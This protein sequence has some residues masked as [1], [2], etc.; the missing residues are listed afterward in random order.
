MKKIVIATNN[1]NKIKEISAILK[2]DDV[3]FLSLKDLNI[4]FDVEETGLTFKKNA[5]KKA[6]EYYKLCKLPVIAE[7]SGLEIKSLNGMPGV[8]SKRIYDGK[9]EY[10]GNEIILE[11]LKG[12]NDRTASYVASYCYYDGVKKLFAEGRTFGRIAL[13]Q[14]GENGFAYDKIFISD[15]FKK[16]MSMISDEEKN[17][18]SHR[19]RGLDLLKDKINSLNKDIDAS[20]SGFKHKHF[21]KM[22]NYLDGTSMSYYRYIDK[23]EGDFISESVPHTCFVNLITGEILAKDFLGVDRLEEIPFTHIEDYNFSIG[24]LNSLK[25]AGINYIEEITYMW[26]KKRLCSIKGFGKSR[27][28]ELEEHGIEIFKK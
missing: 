13:K 28:K 10:D 12:E 8:F 16:L 7:D 6:I 14:E 24:L 15:D 19:R 4:D 17:N 20:C 22:D 21:Y 18:I 5:E 9:T 23:E 3:E 25:R 27:L 2:L 1:K 11:N 26:D